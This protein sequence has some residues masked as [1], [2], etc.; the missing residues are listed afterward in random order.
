[1]RSFVLAIMLTSTPESMCLRT[2]SGSEHFVV[3]GIAEVLV[4]TGRLCETSGL[5]LQI[6]YAGF[7]AKL[8]HDIKVMIKMKEAISSSTHGDGK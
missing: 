5:L 1:M 3:D 8:A 2:S 6:V 7:I 4:L